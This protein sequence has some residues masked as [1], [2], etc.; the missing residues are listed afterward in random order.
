MN[1][2][3]KGN[4]YIAIPAHNDGISF[5]FTLGSWDSEE[6]DED[7][8][9]ISNRTYKFGYAD[10]LRLKVENWEGFDDW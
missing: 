10:T 3:L 8:S 7:G 9:T 4:Y 2:N 6:L 5:K 1:R